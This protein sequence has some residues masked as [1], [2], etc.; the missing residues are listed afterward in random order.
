VLVGVFNGH[1]DLMSP[2]LSRFLKIS[3]MNSAAFKYALYADVFC[4]LLVRW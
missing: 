3:L 1:S 4:S 2:L